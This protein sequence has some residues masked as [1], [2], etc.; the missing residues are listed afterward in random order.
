LPPN[1]GICRRSALPIFT[2]TTCYRG[3]TAALWLQDL[4]LDLEELDFVIDHLA[5][6]GSKGTTGTQASFLELFDGDHDKCVELDRIIAAKMGFSRTYAVAGQ[7]YPRKVDARVSVS[8]LQS[9]RARQNSATTSGSCS[10]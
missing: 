1:T 5:L 8:C 3:Q 4:L 6:L 10:T 2:G 7:T 9:R